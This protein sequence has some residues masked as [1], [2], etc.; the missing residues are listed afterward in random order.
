MAKITAGGGGS[1][2]T[3][4]DNQEVASRLGE[5]RPIDAK[6]EFPAAPEPSLRTKLTAIRDSDHPAAPWAR[7]VVQCM[8]ELAQRS[9]DAGTLRALG[10]NVAMFERAYHEPTLTLADRSNLTLTLL[11]RLTSAEI[12][13]IFGLREHHPSEH[14]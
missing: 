14:Q 3:P 4:Q 6:R 11:P 1:F 9:D 13:S 10:R 5:N 7:N 2:A 8:D 12:A